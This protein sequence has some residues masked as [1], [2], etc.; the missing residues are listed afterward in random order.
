MASRRSKVVD[1]TYDD[2]YRTDA[3]K[4]DRRVQEV[5]WDQIDDIRSR[6]LALFRAPSPQRRDDMVVARRDDRD[7]NDGD[8]N[9]QYF[10]RR[11]V[12]RERFAD[13]D[14]RL[15]PPRR[16]QRPRSSRRRTPSPSSSSSESSRERRRRRTRHR[17]TASARE[18]SPADSADE[19]I[20][21]WSH[22]KR[23]EGNV[24]ERN[25]DPSYD[26]IIAGIAGAA[27]GGITARR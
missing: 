17:R 4:R 23:C 10:M 12:T 2:D 19:H 24:V 11:T 1:V 5:P 8:D 13:N 6:E 7:D 21:F 3:K 14:A 18:P 22:K 16:R 25:L 20:L 9:D 26:G 27:I 15:A